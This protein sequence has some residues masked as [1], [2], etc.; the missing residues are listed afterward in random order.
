[1]IPLTVVKFTETESIIAIVR[2][3]RGNEELF[4]G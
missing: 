4:N 3:Q 1:M 2:G